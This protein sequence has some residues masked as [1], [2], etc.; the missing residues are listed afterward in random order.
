MTPDPESA[1]SVG[2]LEMLDQPQEVVAENICSVRET[3]AEVGA[4]V[5]VAD[6][7]Y[8]QELE[9]D[10]LMRTVAK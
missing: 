7:A 2:G 9:R 4:E 10:K 1:Q 6:K 5:A 8:K 3:K